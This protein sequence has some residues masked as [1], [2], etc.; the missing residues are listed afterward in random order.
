MLAFQI[1]GSSAKPATPDL[2]RVMTNP[3]AF[4]SSHRAIEALKFI[5]HGALPY[6]LF[7]ATNSHIATR[8]NVPQ[9][10]AYV[11]RYEN[12]PS[13]VGVLC[14]LLNDQ[15][16]RVAE[17]AAKALVTLGVEPAVTV[18]ALIKAAQDQR[19][20]GLRW[21]AVT[22]LGKFGAQVRPAIPV[23]VKCLND[24]NV[25][26]RFRAIQ[27][28][29]TLRLEPGLVV[30]ALTRKSVDKQHPG[31]QVGAMEALAT[32]GKA[33]ESAVPVILPLLDDSHIELRRAATNALREIA[34]ERLQGR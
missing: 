17:E 14:R 8:D 34:P 28:L 26:V 13:A 20:N 31:E 7:A 6:L 30:P 16:A 3:G 9:A 21:E 5:G 12:A 18:P 4:S 1:L 19:S 15:D 24:Q 27:A 10:I 32:F 22:A 29:R 2:N 11:A 33:A 25:V 23:L